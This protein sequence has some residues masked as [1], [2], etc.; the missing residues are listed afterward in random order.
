MSRVMANLG[1]LRRQFFLESL[2]N[3]SNSFN[4]SLV[5]DKLKDFS[6]FFEVVE[7]DNLISFLNHF[8]KNLF[9]S[10]INDAS[11]K[12]FLKTGQRSGALNSFLPKIF[13][14]ALPKTFKGV[15]KAFGGDLHNQF[16]SQK[17]KQMRRFDNFS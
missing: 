2:I 6:C 16:L 8:E 11:F 3:L 1:H 12:S 14:Q 10:L 15:L 17:A 4:D 13:L 5:L 9:V 7:M